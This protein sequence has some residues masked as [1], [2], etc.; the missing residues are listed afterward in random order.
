M[1]GTML[2]CSTETRSPP[3]S[4]GDTCGSPV[5]CFTQSLLKLQEAQELLKTAQAAAQQSVPVG[6]VI[7]F[8]GNGEPDHWMFCDG[9][10]LDKNDSRYSA[11]FN[12]I[13]TTHGGDASPNFQIPDYRGVFLRG[14]DGGANRDPD[15]TARIAMGQN[16][17]GSSGAGVGTYQDDALQTHRHAVINFKFG[18]TGS[19]GSK[20]VD[21]GGDKFNSDPNFAALSFDVGDPTGARVTGETRPK[22]VSVRWLIKVE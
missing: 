1:F 17:S 9:R 16:G 10:T 22:N 6:T 19:N 13:G 2:A 14:V 11:L 20:D 12:A 3:V 4:Y 21:R 18:A 8:S 7:A 15:A 5:E